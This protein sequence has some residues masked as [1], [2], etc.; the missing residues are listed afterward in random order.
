VNANIRISIFLFT[1]FICFT[2]LADLIQSNKEI[3]AR[4][5]AGDLRFISKDSAKY[6]YVGME[7]CA[8]VCHN[9]EDMGFQYNIMKNGPHSKSYKIL[10]SERAF[11]Y[12]KKNNIKDDPQNSKVC[13]KCHIT[14]GGSDSTFFATTYRK[15]EGVTCEACHKAE[16]ITKAFI[17][18]EADCLRCHNNSVHKVPGFN[19]R[20][21]CSKIAHRR[22]APKIKEI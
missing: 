1:S 8:S 9:N 21:D 6:L 18:E 15:D 11:Q 17:P 4:L 13:L 19:F 7:K 3:H 20:E 10:V 22:P 12:A 14:G 2:F 16:F 5:L